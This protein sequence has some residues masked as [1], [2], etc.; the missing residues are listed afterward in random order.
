MLLFLFFVLC[1]IRADD[2]NF[3]AY[4]DT[5]VNEEPRGKGSSQYYLT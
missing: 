5:F 2:L 1:G 3:E 4:I